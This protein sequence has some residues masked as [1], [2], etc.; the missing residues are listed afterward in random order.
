MPLSGSDTPQFVTG[1]TQ[2]YIL[3]VD[4][5]YRGDKHVMVRW[6]L[7]RFQHVATFYKSKI[8]QQAFG[9]RQAKNIPVG[10]FQ[11]DKTF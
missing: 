10:L 7:L 3:S 5:K 8:G 1:N 9:N 4:W 2:L 11:L 6:K